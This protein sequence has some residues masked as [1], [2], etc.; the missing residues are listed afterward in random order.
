MECPPP[1]PSREPPRSLTTTLA[2]SLASVNAYSRPS[3][4]PAPVTTMTRSCT[5]GIWFLPSWVR[6]RVASLPPLEE[7]SG[8][9]P[10]LL[11]IRGIDECADVGSRH[12]RHHGLL[13]AEPL[14]PEPA[15][16]GTHARWSDT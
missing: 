15:V 13:V 6:P 8:E 4:P 7:P 16:V 11:C 10:S 14:E 5:P 2:P 1:V 9:L 12:F 3:P